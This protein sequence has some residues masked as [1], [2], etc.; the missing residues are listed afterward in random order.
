MEN[1][2]SG[3]IVLLV[4]AAPILGLLFELESSSKPDIVLHAEVVARAHPENGLAQ[5]CVVVAEE[6]DAA[7]IHSKYDEA[8]RT[9][10][11]K[12]IPIP[13]IELWGRSC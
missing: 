2:R 1:I 6:I 10:V 7:P 11:C 12:V 8:D 4:F 9:T 13:C 5:A 3:L